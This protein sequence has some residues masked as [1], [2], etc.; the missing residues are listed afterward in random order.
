MEERNERG[1]QYHCHLQPFPYVIN[2]N[3]LIYIPGE[4]W[5]T[6]Q[7]LYMDNGSSITRASPGVCV[8]TLKLAPKKEKRER[9]VPKQYWKQLLAETEDKKRRKR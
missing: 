1:T 9:V 6:I 3:T 4:L 2:S 8:N 5:D 7:T